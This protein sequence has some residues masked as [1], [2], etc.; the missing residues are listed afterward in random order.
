MESLIDARDVVSLIDICDVVKE[1]FIDR[2]IYISRIEFEQSELDIKSYITDVKSSLSFKFEELKIKYEVLNIK[3][4]DLSSKFEK[5]KI[6]YEVLN[7]ENKDLN[8]RNNQS[9]NLFIELTDKVQIL[10]KRITELEQIEDIVKE[11]TFNMPPE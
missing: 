10:D 9:I 7:T 5:L 4:K 11:L 1:T 3:N 8:N 6:K 2:S